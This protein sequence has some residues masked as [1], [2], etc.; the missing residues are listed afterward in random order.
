MIQ[1]L[2]GGLIVEDVKVGEG[3]A[4]PR[5]AT[6]TIHY[7]GTLEME[8]SLIPAAMGSQRHFRCAA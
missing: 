8:H 2:A 5:N 1:E 7:T 3:I 4:C 6:V